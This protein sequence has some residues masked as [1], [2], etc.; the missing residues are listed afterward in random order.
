MPVFSVCD[1]V[2]GLVSSDLN[3]FLSME[4]NTVKL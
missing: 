4:D 1:S 3:Q 2:Q